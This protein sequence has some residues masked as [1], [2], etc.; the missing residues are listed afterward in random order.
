M[1]TILKVSVQSRV[2]TVREQSSRIFQQFLISYPMAKKRLDHHMQQVLSNIQYEYEN[3]RKSALQLLSNLID[4]VISVA[5]NRG[6]C[7][8]R[9]FFTISSSIGE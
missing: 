1:E 2:D 4:A 9:L 6:V 7:S 8:G 5:I 3:G